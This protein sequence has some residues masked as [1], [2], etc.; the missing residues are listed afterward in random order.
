MTLLTDF[1]EHDK[2][3]VACKINKSFYGLK[4][5]PR[6]WFDRFMKMIKGQEYQQR[7]SDH[8]MFFEQSQDRLKTI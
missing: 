8:T 7:Q 1:Y 2:N 3:N 5:S 4:Q 6:A